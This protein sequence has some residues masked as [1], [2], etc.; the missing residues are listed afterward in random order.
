MSNTQDVVIAAVAALPPTIVAIAAWRSSKAT[1]REVRTTDGSRSGELVG[2]VAKAVSRL[3]RQ[4][5]LL[6]ARQRALANASADGIFETDSAG[7]YTWVSTGWSV[8][9]GLS[10]E[11]AIGRGWIASV[12]PEDRHAVVSAWDCAT[13]DGRPF[14]PMVFRL[15]NSLTVSVTLVSE[16]ASVV[17][18]SD[19]EIDGWVGTVSLSPAVIDSTT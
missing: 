19:G 6:S 17:R 15:L 3:E 8:L 13:E 11:Q 5:H 10:T 12:H 2:S 4:V 14:G 16:R 9:T 1:H 18:S 7:N